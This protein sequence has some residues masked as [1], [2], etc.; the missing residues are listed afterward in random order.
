MRCSRC[1]VKL[2]RDARDLGVIFVIILVAMLTI[3]VVTWAAIPVI[4]P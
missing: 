2:D 1:S 3:G 4:I